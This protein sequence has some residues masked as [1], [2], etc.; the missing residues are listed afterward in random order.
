MSRSGENDQNSPISE[1][2]IV[3]TFTKLINGEP[4]ALRS[5][6]HVNHQMVMSLLDRPVINGV[7]T[8]ELKD[9]PGRKEGHIGLQL[10][11][12]QEM[13]VEYKDIKV[14]VAE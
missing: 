6:F 9:D 8:A 7:V 3:D 12:G 10:H 14:S 4:E 5:H 11:G 13:H 2:A 1:M